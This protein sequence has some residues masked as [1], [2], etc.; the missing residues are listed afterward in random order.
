[1][2]GDGVQ[3]HFSPIL[4][5]L[6]LVEDW[7]PDWHLLIAVGERG[8]LFS[9]DDFLY[10]LVGEL[11]AISLR[12]QG[13]VRR[14]MFQG[15]RCWSMASSIQSMAGGAVMLKNLGTFEGDSR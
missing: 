12:N 7:S 11:S 9:F 4:V 6:D 13:Q 10:P 14:R 5:G 8:R 2:P 1:M 3:S 15:G